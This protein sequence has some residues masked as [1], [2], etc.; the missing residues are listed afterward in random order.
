[1]DR[2]IIYIVLLLI[3]YYSN[4]IIITNKYSCFI[5]CSLIWYALAVSLKHPPFSLLIY[6]FQLK[7][8]SSDPPTEEK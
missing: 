6:K 4:N 7:F 2:Y 3:I 5:G 8:Q 1:M